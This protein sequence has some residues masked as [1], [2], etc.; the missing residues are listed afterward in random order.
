MSVGKI[1]MKS[2][3]LK[4]WPERQ[5]STKFRIDIQALRGFAVI[6]VLLYHAGIGYFSYGFLG[7]DVFFVISG[8]LM[9]RLIKEGIERGD[10]SFSK[11]YFRRAKRLLPAAYTTFFI[12]ALCSRYF[13]ASNEMNDFRWQMVGALTFMSNI[14]LWKQTGYF[15]GAAELKPLLHAWSLSIEEQYY[16]IL[17][18]MMFFIPRRFW[19]KVGF[20]SFLLSFVASQFLVHRSVDGT[21]YLLWTRVW[22]FVVGSFGAFALSGGR[23][24]RCLQVAF[25]PALGVLLLLPMVNMAHFHPGPDAFLIC[26]ATLIIILRKHP[27]LFRGRLVKGLAWTGDISYSLYLI[28]WPLLAFLNNAWVGDASHPLP[29]IGWRLG[30][31]ALSIVL[32]LLLNRLVEEPLRRMDIRLTKP[33]L[34]RTVAVSLILLV[35]PFG[36][37]QVVATEK[38][39]ANI[40]RKN[41]GFD[42]KCTFKHGLF[43]PLAECRNSDRPEILVWGDSFAMHL[44]AGI[45]GD[46]GDSPPLVQA[47]RSLCGPFLDLCPHGDG[48]EEAWGRDCMAFNA[49]VMDYV[50]RQDSLK[51]VV[52]SSPFA[53]YLEPGRKNWHLMR[54]IGEGRF[55]VVEVNTDI[56]VEAMKKTVDTLRSLGKKVVVVAPPPN[57]GFDSGLCLERLE[58]GL[59]ILG[60]ENECSINNDSRMKV[61]KKVLEFLSLASREADVEVID[62]ADFLCSE[63]TCRTYLDGTFLYRDKGHL[64]YDGAAL[65]GKKIG[66]ADKITAAAR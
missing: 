10:F 26:I 64:S 11:F 55:D 25:W 18:A 66:L 48:Y 23:L 60:S 57:G 63:G 56:A 30:L 14:V 54:R 51:I 19:K 65:I 43:Q 49:S 20:W 12:T 33:L 4:I 2:S 13:L 52:L 59:P 62:F 24:E 21:F 42:R 37:H 44:V 9:T 15:E 40:R 16:F 50:A 8:F 45:L 39:Y 38:D 3:L 58:K 35:L 7:V 31:L 1:E 53:H 32:A 46:T 17:P 34:V 5:D 41:H 28:H 6:V 36:I 29:P 47:T 22:E 27:V 61:Q